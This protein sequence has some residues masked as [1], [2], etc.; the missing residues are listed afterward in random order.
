M[1]NRS[2][3]LLDLINGAKLDNFLDSFTNVTGVA[4]IIADAS[5]QPITKAHNFSNLCQEYCRCSKAGRQKCWESDRFGGWN[6]LHLRNKFVYQCLNAGLIDSAYPIVVDGYHL[7][8]ALCGQVLFEPIETEVAVERATSIEVENIDGY[9]K[10]LKKIPIMPPRSFDEIVKHMQIV[11]QT[12][13]ELALQKYLSTQRSRQYLNKLINSV[14][15]G[16]V[17]TNDDAVISIVN[18]GCAR[19]FECEKKK[20]IGQ[21]LYSLFSDAAS[22]KA[23][24]EEIKSRP[25]R[26]GRTVLTAVN[27][28]KESF[29]VQISIS[30]FKS[31]NYKNSG[32]VAVLRDISEE[33]KTEQMKEDLIGML[34]HDMGNPVLSIQKALQLMVDGTLGQLNP[35]Q[36]EI[37]N[38]ALSTNHQLFGIVSD[39]LDIYRSENGKFLLRK[40]PTDYTQIIEE[41]AKYLQIFAMDKQLSISTQLPNSPITL[42]G[43]RNRLIR[44]LSN[45]LDNAIR[46]SPNGSR[47]EIASSIL[48]R[49]NMDLS[50]WCAT[51]PDKSFQIDFDRDYVLT[52]ITDQGPGIPKKHQ[53]HIFEKFYTIR[54]S[55]SRDRKALGLGL[56][57]CK[58]V[59]ESH[60]GAIWVT[61]PLNNQK[62][63]QFVGSRFAFIL[64]LS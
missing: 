19:M 54:S 44:T 59:I 1:M 47:I 48:S 16:I 24:Q 27:T 8:T 26:N 12:I 30:R 11:V 34:T 56:A 64:P 32:Y 3:R 13:S 63:D 57:F 6:S 20:L 9:L 53:K 62:N 33:K 39:F 52:A 28:R 37:M 4:A 10:E 45:L 38:L 58:L 23:C 14:C 49:E 17:S 60:K 51:P 42:P 31:D 21:S 55:K 29:P 15:D 40:M 2:I 36:M 50:K 22:V 25:H 43:D 61:S 35:K 18:E 5:G 41:G 7:A 46:F